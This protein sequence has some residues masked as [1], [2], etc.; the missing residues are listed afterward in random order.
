[1]RIFTAPGAARRDRSAVDLT[2]DGL[3]DALAP[4]TWAPGGRDWRGHL[5]VV[6]DSLGVFRA[7]QIAHGWSRGEGCTPAGIRE[8]LAAR[9][10]RL[11][12]DASR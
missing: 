6:I 1:M 9:V 11:R 12:A 3:A 4:L 7:D 5:G 10:E 8:H 2:S